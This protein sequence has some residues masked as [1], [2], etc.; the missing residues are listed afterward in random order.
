MY[1]GMLSHTKLAVCAKRTGLRRGD[2]LAIW[3]ALLDHA[4]TAVPRG[5]V[6]NIDPE[7]IAV[8]LDFD[9]AAIEL[10]FQSFR[11]KALILEDGLLEDWEKYQTLSTP[12]VRAHRARQQTYKEPDLDTDDESEEAVAKR[13]QRLREEML[14]RH[15]RK[16]RITTD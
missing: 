5:S 9:P 14:M 3:V 1:P 10:A 7:E 13:R 12:R 8:Y 2:V 16:G 6:K 11:D 4:A 15:K